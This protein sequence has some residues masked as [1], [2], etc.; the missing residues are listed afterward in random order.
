MK[1]FLV[2]I[3]ISRETEFFPIIVCVC[4]VQMTEEEIRKG[5]DPFSNVEV[6]TRKEA[7]LPEEK[8]EVR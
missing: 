8:K 6:A 4:I 5:G 3:V 1:A 7:G 2:S